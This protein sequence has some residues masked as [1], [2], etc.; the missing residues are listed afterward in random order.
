[1]W[2]LRRPSV[3]RLFRL[4]IFLQC[5]SATRLRRRLA[6]DLQ[7]RSRARASVL[8][9]FRT[10]VEPMHRKYVQPQC[11]HADL[12]LRSP[13]SRSQVLKLTKA[14]TEKGLGSAL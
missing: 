5:P 10:A 3:R 9:Q 2:L 1:L 4:K 14:I 8:W 13:C 6:R 11:S 7:G 12:I